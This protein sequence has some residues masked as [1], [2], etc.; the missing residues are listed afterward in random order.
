MSTEP[1]KQAPPCSS[2]SPKYSPPSPAANTPAPKASPSM[3][4]S[5]VQ[6]ICLLANA[7]GAATSEALDP[8]LYGSAVPWVFV[9]LAVSALATGCLVWMLFYHLNRAGDDMNA[10]D[11]DYDADPMLGRESVVGIWGGGEILRGGVCGVGRRREW[12]RRDCRVLDVFCRT[13]WGQAM[14]K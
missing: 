10:L 11:Q 6:A 4:C 8:V 14:Y 7:F 2:A 9:T 13:S 3:K 5:F 1:P 12:L